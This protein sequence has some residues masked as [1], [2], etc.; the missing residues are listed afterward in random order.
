MQSSC[1]HCGGEK[2]LVDGVHAEEEGRVEEV[3]AQRRPLHTVQLAV[4]AGAVVEP[5]E[6]CSLFTPFYLLKSVPGCIWSSIWIG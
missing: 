2:N 3:E 5:D 6:A 1:L 4:A